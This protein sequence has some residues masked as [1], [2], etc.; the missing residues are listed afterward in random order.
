ML[1]FCNMSSSKDFTIAQRK[2]YAKLLYVNQGHTAKEA[3]R[4]AGVSERSMSKWVNEEG[5]DK[6]RASMAV[7]KAAQIQMMYAQLNELNNSIQLK[8]EGE[9]YADSKQADSMVKIAAAIKSFE[10]DMSIA[11]SLDVLMRFLDYVRSRNLATAQTLTTE[12][13]LYIKSLVR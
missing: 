12:V 5:W 4:V 9:R 7:T 1:Q 13:D 3:G 11:E 10:V 2:N 8:P 6:L